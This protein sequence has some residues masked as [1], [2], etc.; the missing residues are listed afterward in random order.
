MAV[1][2]TARG[3]WD[4]VTDLQVS[5]P[6]VEVTLGVSVKLLAVLVVVGCVGF[7]LGQCSGKR[8]RDQWW[9]DSI[10]ASSS[11]VREVMSQ[12]QHDI[13]RTDELIL[14]A[15]EGTDAKLKAAEEELAKARNRPNR[16]GCPRIPAYCVR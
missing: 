1:L 14:K 7:L 16:D 5:P 9:R 3:L 15:L 10:A 2:A 4:R 8:E 11:A 13:D 6:R 12:Q